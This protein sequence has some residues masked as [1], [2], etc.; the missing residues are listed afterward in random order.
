MDLPR[1]R[2]KIDELVGFKNQVGVII[3][4]ASCHLVGVLY[5]NLIIVGANCIRP[6]MIQMHFPNWVQW[7]PIIRITGVFAG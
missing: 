2:R 3:E 6:I 5:P 7:H 1:A 4:V